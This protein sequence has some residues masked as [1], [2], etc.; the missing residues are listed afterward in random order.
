MEQLRHNRKIDEIFDSLAHDHHR[1]QLSDL[2]D[3]ATEAILNKKKGPR[4]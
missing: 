3:G 2:L 1:T 4:Q